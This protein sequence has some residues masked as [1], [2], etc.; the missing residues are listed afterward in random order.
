MAFLRRKGNTFYL[1]HNVREG[2]RVRQLYLAK[3]GERPRITDDVVRQVSRSHPFLDVNWSQ[4]REQVNNRVE[5]YDPKSNQIQR[6][7][8]TLRN[9]NLDLADLFPPLLDVSQAPEASL[10]IIMQLRLLHS[11]VGVKLDQFDRAPHRGVLA[12]R[13]FR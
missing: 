13:K 1:V 5:L 6:L 10:E 7:V 4:L 8:S 3:L 11:T 12:A 9:L 2:G